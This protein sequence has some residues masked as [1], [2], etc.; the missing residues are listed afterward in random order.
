MFNGEYLFYSLKYIVINFNVVLSRCKKM[1]YPNLMILLN[2]KILLFYLQQ[3]MGVLFV[4]KYRTQRLCR[5]TRVR[6]NS[7]WFIVFQFGKSM[8]KIKP[9]QRLPLKYSSNQI[10]NKIDTM[11]WT[12]DRFNLILEFF[13]IY[14]SHLVTLIKLWYY[15]LKFIW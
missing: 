8:Q 7:I 3:L 2:G 12:F 1:F 13:I 6:L 10:V 11:S 15:V 14:D 9:I 5:R 4:Q